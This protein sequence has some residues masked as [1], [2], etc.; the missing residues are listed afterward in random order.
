MDTAALDFLL[1]LSGI[2]DRFPKLTLI[3]TGWSS[4][5]IAPWCDAHRDPKTGHDFLRYA[6]EGRLYVALD[7]AMSPTSIGQI[8]DSLSGQALVWQSHFPLGGG[9][10]GWRETLGAEASDAIL[11][12][13]AVRAFRLGAVAEIA[14]REVAV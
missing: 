13:N 11:R 5:W 12:E 10:A 7:S 3:V 9:T 8:V 6:L 14:Q 1:S 2:L 4:D